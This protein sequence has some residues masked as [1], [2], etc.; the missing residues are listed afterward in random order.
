MFAPPINRRRLWHAPMRDLPAGL[1]RPAQVA[2][3]G[4]FQFHGIDLAGVAVNNFAAWGDEQGMGD[5]AFPFGVEGF[6]Q[7]LF[8]AAGVNVV[9]RR[10]FEVFESFQ[11]AVF[12][13]GFIH[14]DG[15]EFEIALAVHAIHFD[16]FGE[17]DDAGGAPG[18]PDVYEAEFFAVIFREG[19][20][21]FEFD[22]G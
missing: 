17:L 22:G 5:G 11:G 19:F 2:H 18:G 21:G 16:E 14:A 4:L 15:D 9:G 7:L 6:D 20:D 12:F 13:L 10:D 1:I 8:V 3:D